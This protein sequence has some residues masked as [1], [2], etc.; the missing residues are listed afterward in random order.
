MDFLFRQADRKKKFG[1]LTALIV[2]YRK[3]LII[4]QD[5]Q[6]L[7]CA[8]LGNYVSEGGRIK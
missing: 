4:F 6:C 3:A 1:K 8:H 7:F 2:E 5:S